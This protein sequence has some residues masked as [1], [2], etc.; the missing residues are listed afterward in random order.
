MI[1][2]FSRHANTFRRPVVVLAIAAAF[3]LGATGAAQAQVSVNV[4]VNASTPG[5]LYDLGTVVSLFVDP[6]SVEPEPVAV[7]WAP[8]PMLVEE[9]PPQPDQIAVWTGGYGRGRATGSGARAVGCSRRARPTSGCS[10][11]TNIATNG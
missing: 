2:S 8:P 4:D 5:W 7:A 9:P 3:G 6:P 11:T 1:Q 10:P